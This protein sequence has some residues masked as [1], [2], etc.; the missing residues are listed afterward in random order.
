M[1]DVAGVLGRSHRDPAKEPSPPGHAP[2][3]RQRF[4]G[5]QG[6]ALAEISDS[7]DEGPEAYVER[8]TAPFAE[9]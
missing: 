4:E 1:A 8:A 6:K 5:T 9:R 7:S 2:M 3:R